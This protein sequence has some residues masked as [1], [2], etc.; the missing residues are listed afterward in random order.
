MN[1][2]RQAATLFIVL[3]AAALAALA[4]CSGSSAQVLPAT[5]QDGGMTDGATGPS[6]TGALDSTTFPADSGASQVDSGTTDSTAHSD[7]GGGDAGGDAP[8]TGCLGDGGLDCS[9]T[10]QVCD[11]STNT[12][13]DCLQ[14]SDCD[15][16]FA[17]FCDPQAKTCVQCLKVADCPFDSP[18]CFQGSCGGCGTVA[19]CPPNNTCAGADVPAGISG[20]CSCIDNTGCGG[21]AP[22]CVVS[23]AGATSACG[24]TADS[25]C[26]NGQRCGTSFG[27]NGY[28]F[29]PC[30][31]DAGACDP[32]GALPYCMTSSGMCAECLTD[33]QCASALPTTPYCD[34]T[35]FCAQ[36][37]VDG[38]C[39][40]LDAGTPYC[41]QETCSACRTYQDCPASMPG[42]DSI[43][44]SCGSCS[45]D[46]DCP[47]GQACLGPLGNMCMAVDGGAPVDAGGDASVTDAGIHD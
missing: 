3:V 30:T 10:Q 36:C 33:G 5:S 37:L 38:N 27:S 28:C 34:P 18:G 16:S 31:E 39:A 11:P 46:S 19:D 29:D 43:L 45:L 44:L 8:A 32:T 6:D 23:D 9:Q 40:A 22:T 25:Q 7:S 13:V 12:C 17:P 14:N 35:S 41:L 15:P 1:T 20:Q 47:P 24:C 21:D 26:P 4:G 2:L 42:C